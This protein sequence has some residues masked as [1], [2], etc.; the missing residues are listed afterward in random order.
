MNGKPESGRKA[1]IM[2]KGQIG[3]PSGKKEWQNE[4]K[5]EIGQQTGNDEEKETP[6]SYRLI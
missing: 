5:K 1:R 4:R 3:E 2:A 6:N